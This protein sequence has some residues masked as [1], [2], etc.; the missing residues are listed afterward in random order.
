MEIERCLKL[1]RH[2]SKQNRDLTELSSEFSI[3][4]KFYLIK[5]DL[6]LD[7]EACT[8]EILQPRA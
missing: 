4:F 1:E 3:S 6:K 7:A 5:K 2:F 8:K